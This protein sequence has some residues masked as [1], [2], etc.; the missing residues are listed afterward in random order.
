M[1]LEIGR[2][3]MRGVFS[4]GTVSVL[5]AGV[6][7]LA[8][9]ACTR[10]PGITSDWAAMGEP[11]GWEPKAGAC[12][13]EFL[14][15]AFRATYKPVDCTQDHRYET[16]AIGQFTGDAA[17]LSAPPTAGSAEMKAAWADCDAKTTA[18]LGGDWR[19]GKIWIG[20]SV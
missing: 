19:D 20:V 5:L 9:S 6:V 17:N 4:R 13:T 10:A 1:R 16:V 15:Q 12:Q 2:P 11:A 7:L 14:V 18:F 3:L 8:V